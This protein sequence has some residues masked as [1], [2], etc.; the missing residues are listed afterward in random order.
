M[1][2]DPTRSARTHSAWGVPLIGLSWLVLYFAIRLYLEANPGLPR[3][4]RLGLAFVPT[5]V[6]A[7]LLWQFIKGI[8]GADE[9]ERRIQLEALGVAFPLGVLLL[10]TLG[11]VQRAVELNFQ[12]WSYN[13]V[14][15][16]FVMF[17][18]TGLMFARRRYA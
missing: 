11:L 16:F 13:H 12:D 14:W 3:G 8:R 4:A 2:T 6:F 5:P 17:Y 9:L 10:T 15:P 18:L 1:S 7:L